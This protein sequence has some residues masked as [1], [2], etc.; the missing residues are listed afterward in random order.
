MLPIVLACDDTSVP[1][2]C[3]AHATQVVKPTGRPLLR[4]D[5]G[6]GGRRRGALRGTKNPSGKSQAKTA[7]ILLRDRGKDAPLVRAWENLPQGTRL[8]SFMVFDGEHAVQ[9]DV[10]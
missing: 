2:A 3:E 10:H 8:D 7:R 1:V 5:R 4:A 6:P 9:R